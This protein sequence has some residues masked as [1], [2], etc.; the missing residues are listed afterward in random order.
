MQLIIL[1]VRDVCPKCQRLG[2]ILI[3]SHSSGLRVTAFHQGGT[4][5]MTVTEDVLL[6][7]DIL[8]LASLLTQRLVLKG[9]CILC[10]KPLSPNLIDVYRHF[11]KEHS[12]VFRLLLLDY[13]QK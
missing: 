6:H 8:R 2:N 11:E 12:D 5:T 3:E 13:M 9:R 1:K 4:C 7:E 10:Q